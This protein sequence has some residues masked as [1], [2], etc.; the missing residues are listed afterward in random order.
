MV[1]RNGA[2]HGGGTGHE[3]EQGWRKGLVVDCCGNRPL[4][5]RQTD[6]VGLPHAGGRA[7]HIGG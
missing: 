3:G 5:P 2:R 1:V 6:C 7:L 4:Q